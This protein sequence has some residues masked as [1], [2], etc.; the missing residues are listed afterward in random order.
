M[1]SPPQNMKPYLGRGIALCARTLLRVL[2]CFLTNRGGSKGGGYGLGSASLRRTWE[3]LDDREQVD[4]PMVSTCSRK[5]HP[6]RAAR[7]TLASDR[8]DGAPALSRE[9]DGRKGDAGDFIKLRNFTSQDLCISLR[10]FGEDLKAASFRL[11]KRTALE[12]ASPAS[13]GERRRHATRSA[14]RPPNN[15]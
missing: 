7:R 6:Q 14:R 15:Y 3:G 1:L 8:K 11:P 5:A 10:S 12:L 13:R 9:G 4:R 2:L